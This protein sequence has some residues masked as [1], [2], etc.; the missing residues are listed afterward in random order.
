MDEEVE[1]ID[2]AAVVFVAE[3]DG[4]VAVESGEVDVGKELGGEVAD[5][6]AF[7]GGL[8]EEAFGAGEVAP[9]AGAAFSGDVFDGVVEDD[10]L[11]EEAEGVVELVAFGELAVEAPA[12]AF[13]ETIAGE[14]HEVAADV[15]LD[16]ESFDFVVF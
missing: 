8:A 5:D 11:P 14:G 13:E 2:V 10:L 3:G 1:I 15:E 12:D 16:D 9:V 7:A 4:H 6:D